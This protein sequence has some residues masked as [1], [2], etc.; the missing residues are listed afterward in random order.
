MR[1]SRFRLRWI[2]VQFLTLRMLTIMPKYPKRNFLFFIRRSSKAATSPSGCILY[3]WRL[4][5]GRLGGGVCR[6]ILVSGLPVWSLGLG[7]WGRE[8]STAKL[9][10]DVQSIW[11]H[12]P[13]RSRLHQIHITSLFFLSVSVSCSLRSCSP[14]CGTTPAPFFISIFHLS[15]SFFAIKAHTSRLHLAP[16]VVTARQRRE[17]R[18]SAAPT[19]RA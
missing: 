6:L 8:A 17:R 4:G 15:N 5:L 1:G 10:A 18:P 13:L 11:C 19:P 3:R 7:G 12:R 14:L 9:V 16:R 2:S